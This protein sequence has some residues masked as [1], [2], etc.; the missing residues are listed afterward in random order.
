MTSTNASYFLT[1]TICVVESF[2][3]LLHIGCNSFRQWHVEIIQNRRGAANWDHL[4]YSE[5]SEGKKESEYRTREKYIFHLEISRDSVFLGTQKQFFILNYFHIPHPSTVI[6]GIFIHEITYRLRYFCA[7]NKRIVWPNVN[8]KYYITGHCYIDR[9]WLSSAE[10]HNQWTWITVHDQSVVFDKFEYDDI[11]FKLAVGI[12]F[13]AVS[14][15]R[16]ILTC[17]PY[18]NTCI[19]LIRIPLRWLTHQLIKL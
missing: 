15:H 9:N 11:T 1:A 19:R 14:N 2:N 13:I 3:I 12:F 16:Y 7:G 10:V 5:N 17:P 6:V 4:D 8:H 18:P